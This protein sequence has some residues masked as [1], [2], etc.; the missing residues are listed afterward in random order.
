MTKY[1]VILTIVSAVIYAVPL[2]EIIVPGAFI[3][4]TIWLYAT[5]FSPA[6]ILRTIGLPRYFCLSIG[7]S[8]VASLAF[9]P[10]YFAYPI[11]KK[12]TDDL[13]KDDYS[14]ELPQSPRAIRLPPTMLS[15]SSYPNM[16]A[17]MLL[18]HD[19]AYLA[20][21]ARISEGAPSGLVPALP[22][23][24]VRPCSVGRY[25]PATVKP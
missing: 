18:Y 25:A 9:L 12:L 19:S 7:L 24:S 2:I 22:G 21:A 4:P 1:Y 13:I 11:A 14:N 23:I 5:A 6:L 20:S 3:L 8:V 15:I 17:V 16:S 10:N